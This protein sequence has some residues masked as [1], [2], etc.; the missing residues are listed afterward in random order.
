[1][2]VREVGDPRE[3]ETAE[4]YEKQGRFQEDFRPRTQDG[5]LFVQSQAQP[6]PGPW[7]ASDQSVTG[8]RGVSVAYCGQSMISDAGGSY[9]VDLA[10]SR[11]NARLCA[12]APEMLAAARAL[13]A[14]MDEL[15]APIADACTIAELHGSPWTSGNWCAEM[16]SL[17]AAIAKAEGR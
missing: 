7:E 13:L 8:P 14:R 15:A 12:A 5:S 1:M 4:Y 10:E 2:S 11:A 16:E 6:T 17:G 3:P 9:C